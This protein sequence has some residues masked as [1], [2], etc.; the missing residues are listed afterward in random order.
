MSV[1]LF[2][3]FCA[4]TDSIIEKIA[5]LDSLIVFGQRKRAHDPAVAVNGLVRQVAFAVGALDGRTG[6][7]NV[8]I[9]GHQ[10]A[11]HQQHRKGE[12]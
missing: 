12:L 9:A 7:V 11:A 4:L 2:S 8:G 5:V 6:A 1:T 10:N 3:S